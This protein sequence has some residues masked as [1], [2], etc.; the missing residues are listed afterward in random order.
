MGR[1]PQRS[2]SQAP[3]THSSGAA[4]ASPS[5]TRS[6]HVLEAGLHTVVGV[7]P[8]PDII[9]VQGPPV[10]MGGAQTPDAQ[11]NPVTHCPTS[12][13]QGSP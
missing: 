9:G 2:P 3:L 13:V 5:P 12:L 4:Q 7:H 10:A 8:A 1:G 6:T 11:T